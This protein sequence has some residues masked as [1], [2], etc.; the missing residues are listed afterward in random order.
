MEFKM[1]STMGSV[2]KFWE[3]VEQMSNNVYQ[4]YTYNLLLYKYRKTSISNI[5]SFNTKTVFVVAFDKGQAVA[6][7]PLTVNE[8]P[9][10]V[11]L[12][13]YGSNSGSLDFIYNNEKYVQ[14]LFYAC[15]NYLKGYKFDFS[16]VPENSPL[17]HVMNKSSENENFY[18]QVNNYKNYYESL[19]KSMRQN[20]RTSYNRLTTDRKNYFLEV[21]NSISV[22]ICKEIDEV[23]IKRK[24]TW[25]GVETKT[26]NRFRDIVY[27]SVNKLREG[28][29]CILR[30]DNEV[31][32]FFIGYEGEDVIHIPRLA[33]NE[34]YARYSPGIVLINEYL[35][36]EITSIFDLGRGQE[37]YKIKLN[38]VMYK[39]YNLIC[40]VP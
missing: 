22:K 35:K 15:A 25:N 6:I 3:Q 14:P 36:L 32:A 24:K 18:L 21:H 38:G 30:I 12:L 13:G 20:V 2:K 7:A 28:K 23:Y 1:Y 16:F 17:I 27:S 5:K 4:S 33:I 39:T 37:T 40:E 9:R 19:S 10:C 11:R 8:N 34:K 26:V 29:M 31:A